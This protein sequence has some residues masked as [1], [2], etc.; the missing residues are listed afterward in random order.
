MGKLIGKQKNI[1]KNKNGRIDGGDFK[2]IAKIKK[3]KK[4]K[5]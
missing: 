1:D 5:K 4:N 2:I 3:M